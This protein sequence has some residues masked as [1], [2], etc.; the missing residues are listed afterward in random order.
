MVA[1]TPA[2]MTIP[3]R[4]TAAQGI[5]FA[6]STPAPLLPSPLMIHDASLKCA[7][8]GF[9]KAPNSAMTATP[10]ILMAAAEPA[11]LK[12]PA[13]TS[14][15]LTSATPINAT[16]MIA[17]LIIAI[18]DRYATSGS[19]PPYATLVTTHVMILAM[20]LVTTPARAGADLKK[21]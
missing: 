5:V 14:A 7:E 9:A 12:T 11:P 19:V 13:V 6:H 1:S 3:T 17:D 8:M 2:T 10:I 21:G 18:A 20:T 4:Q 15:T 16:L